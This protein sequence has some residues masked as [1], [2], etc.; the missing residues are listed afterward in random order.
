MKALFLL[1]WML[2][3]TPVFSATNYEVE[4]VRAPDE[5]PGFFYVPKNVRGPMPGIFLLHGSEGW[6]DYW[7]KAGDPALPVG[8]N[9]R[10]NKLAYDLASRGFATFALSYF[11][12]RHPSHDNS[13]I[14]KE[15]AYID[16]QRTYRAMQWFNKTY[17]KNDCLILWGYSRGAEQALLLS[18]LTPD[19]KYTSAEGRVIPSIVVAMSP[20]DM[21]RRGISDTLA[22]IVYGEAG[23]KKRFDSL[24]AWRWG[25]TAPGYPKSLD[26]TFSQGFPFSLEKASSTVIITHYEQDTSWGPQGDLAPLVQKVK[27]AQADSLISVQISPMNHLKGEYDNVLKLIDHQKSKQ[28]IFIGYPGKG[29]GWE[30]DS[31]NYKY[32]YQ[33]D[34][35]L[36]I[37]K[38]RIPLTC[39]KMLT[40]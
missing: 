24:P 19:D 11:D 7:Q 34:L 14:P 12:S 36:Q 22:S 35:L 18:S 27:E 17:V 37:V 6:G 32:S 39:A 9:Y 2:F 25:E 10:V 38:G 31:Y 13:T 20:S 4:V 28:R 3:S 29:H 21:V 30:G 16:L 5:F 23:K 26:F 33:I 8:E 1:F 40:L 15:L